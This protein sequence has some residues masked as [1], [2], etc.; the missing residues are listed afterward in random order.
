MDMSGNYGESEPYKI[1]EELDILDIRIE[2]FCI[3]AE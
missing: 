2:Q 3:K 1:W